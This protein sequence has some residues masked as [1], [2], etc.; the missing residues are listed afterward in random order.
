MPLFACY[1]TLLRRQRQ[2]PR[3]LRQQLRRWLHR[4][5]AVHLLGHARMT[6]DGQVV[7]SIK[8]QKGMG[9]L[10][11]LLYHHPKPVPREV[12]MERFWADVLPESA[13]NSLN[14][15]WYSVRKA[16]Q[17]LDPTLDPVVFEQGSYHLHPDWTYAVD[18]Q[19]FL[20]QWHLGRS[21]AHQQG[22][23]AAAEAYQRMVDQYRGDFIE[24]FPYLE[25]VS[26]ER[27]NLREIYLSAL[28]R[29][30]QYQCQQGQYGAACLLGQELLRQDA[31]REGIHRYVML[32]H[33]RLRQ[34]NRALKQ[35]EACCATLQAE[36]GVSPAPLT[37]QLA[38]AMR[39][40]TL[41]QKLID[42]LFDPQR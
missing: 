6:L 3:S 8:S 20:Q 32:A 42:A 2:K 41:S 34:R 7:P 15:A 31:C 38:E 22:L 18:V 4:H 23:A 24:Q 19:T 1:P 37:Q 29:L 5:L 25:W 28:E 39:Q 11:Y 16:F 35:Y 10:A 9:V 13:R 30:C 21:L 17:Q 27:E 26:G 14:V 40:H 36:L 33:Y 12:L